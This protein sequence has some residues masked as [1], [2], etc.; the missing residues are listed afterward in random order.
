MA[1][2]RLQEKQKKT[3]DDSL[4][5]VLK[6]V[7]ENWLQIIE[8]I[9]IYNHSISAFLKN[10]EVVGMKDKFVIVAT[11]YKFHKEKLTQ[12]VNREIVEKVLSEIIGKKK[13]IFVRYLSEEEARKEGYKIKKTLKEKK[14][15]FV[16]SALKIFGGKKAEK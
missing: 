6:T 15:N 2:P 4:D 8:K 1:P 13:K 5:N 3:S 10:C 16:N 9:K 14:E 11:K 12:A 7:E